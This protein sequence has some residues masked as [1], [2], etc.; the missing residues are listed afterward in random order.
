MCVGEMDYL[1]HPHTDKHAARSLKKVLNI[2]RKCRVKQIYDLTYTV[3]SISQEPQ[4][5]E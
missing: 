1:T 2:F 4:V 3:R 5:L